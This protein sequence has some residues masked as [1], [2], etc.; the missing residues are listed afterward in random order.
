MLNPYDEYFR[1]INKIIKNIGMFRFI[2]P[3]SNIVSARAS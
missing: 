1:Q 3:P 2:V